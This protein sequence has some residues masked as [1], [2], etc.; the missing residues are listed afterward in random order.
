MTDNVLS[1]PKSKII[2]DG[3]HNIEELA[4]L[5]T[6]SIQNFADSLTDEIGESIIGAFAING[7]EVENEKFVKDF[8]FL[9]SIINATIYR[10]LNLEHQFHTFIDDN[11]VFT[12]RSEISETE[13]DNPN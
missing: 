5:K 3:D 10:T 1:F 8:H 12:D 2:R 11:V 9:I 7:I 4:K 13:L 6:K